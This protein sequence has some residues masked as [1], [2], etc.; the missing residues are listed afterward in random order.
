MAIGICTLYQ[1]KVGQNISAVGHDE[2]TLGLTD[3]EETK[4]GLIFI[5]GHCGD[6]Y[7][8]PETL[9]KDLCFVLDFL[10]YVETCV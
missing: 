5:K 8:P 1:Q 3:A 10:F 6:Y 7:D 9:R 4:M 2:H